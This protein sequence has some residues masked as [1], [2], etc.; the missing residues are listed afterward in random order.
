MTDEIIKSLNEKKPYDTLRDRRLRP[1]EEKAADY[2]G[3]ARHG[4]ALLARQRAWQIEAGD[5]RGTQFAKRC[6]GC[7]VALVRLY[8]HAQMLV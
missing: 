5:F 8:C 3:I 6:P 1:A 7:G 4:Q 2:L